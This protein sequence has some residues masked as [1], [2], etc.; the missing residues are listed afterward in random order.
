MILGWYFTIITLTYFTIEKY[1]GMCL[2]A[3]SKT[4]SKLPTLKTVQNS[5]IN[6][7]G[8]YKKEK[9]I[10]KIQQ[11][12]YSQKK[13]RMAPKIQIFFYR[14]TIDSLLS[15]NITVYCVSWTR[16]ELHK[17]LWSDSECTTEGALPNLQDNHNMRSETK[18]N[19]II[20]DPCHPNSS[21]F[22]LLQSEKA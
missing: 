8:P 5:R 7:L 12:L 18:A 1:S 13:F 3:Q 11:C 19:K 20:T 6:A 17:V 15:S 2:Q 4:Y 16:Q 14:C 22:L 9:T 21:L 10:S